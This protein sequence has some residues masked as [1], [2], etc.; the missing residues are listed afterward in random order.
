VALVGDGDG[1]FE[2][3]RTQARA[4]RGA[5]RVDDAL[6]VLD[7]ELGRTED[8][9]QR[10]TL[11]L[12]RVQLLNDQYRAAEGLDDLEH[13][14]AA[15]ADGNDPEREIAVQL[16]RGRAYY[17]MSLDNTGMAE[18]SR[19]A[20][21]A[22]YAAAE[23]QG[24]TESMVRALLPTTW[25][26]DYWADYRS[27]AAANMVEARA[28]RADRRRGPDPRCVVG[29]VAS[30]RDVSGIWPIPRRSWR[31]WRSVATRSSSTPTASG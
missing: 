12:Q 20:Y 1:R 19:D 27:T 11:R 22:A 17:I 28:R 24:D 3:R 7:D 13:L 9:D 15:V 30:W 10:F 2:L 4:L 31:D 16:A 23:A 14:V 5:G 29:L 21:E 26:T 25:F 8:P 18:V 6:A